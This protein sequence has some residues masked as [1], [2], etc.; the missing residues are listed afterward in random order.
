MNDLDLKQDH[1]Y[2]WQV[3]REKN[4]N[5]TARCFHCQANERDSPAGTGH[6][7]FT[8]KHL[9]IFVTKSSLLSIFETQS[10][11]VTHISVLA[12]SE[13]A[14]DDSGK[15]Q[16]HVSTFDQEGFFVEGWA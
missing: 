12:F 10:A 14:S 11:N 6:G 2:F 13:G 9:W 4:V 8:F 7:V 3:L 5:V 1:L 15:V 16:T